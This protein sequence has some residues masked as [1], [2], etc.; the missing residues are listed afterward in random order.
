MGPE[1]MTF[2]KAGVIKVFAWDAMHA[3]TLHDSS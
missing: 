3:E 2:R 1:R